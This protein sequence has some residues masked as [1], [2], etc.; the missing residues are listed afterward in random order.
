M[1]KPTRDG[2]ALAR[3]R[4]S[5]QD[6]RDLVRQREMRKAYSCGDPTPFSPKSGRGRCMRRRSTARNSYV[7]C[8]LPLVV[9]D[10]PF[11]YSPRLPVRSLPRFTRFKSVNGALSAPD[12]ANEAPLLPRLAFRHR[13]RRIRSARRYTSARNRPAQVQRRSARIP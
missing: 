3:Q 10:H 13:R 8:P 5:G 6:D 12:I 11:P 4:P 7:L 1:I 9:S 2:D